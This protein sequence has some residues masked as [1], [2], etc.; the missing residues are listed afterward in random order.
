MPMDTVFFEK[1]LVNYKMDCV[2]EHS[3][4][5][6]L[7]RKLVS[8]LFFFDDVGKNCFSRLLSLIDSQYYSFCREETRVNVN[9]VQVFF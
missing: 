5:M 9:F 4:I 3:H 1:Y 6:G 8:S 2:S 7:Q